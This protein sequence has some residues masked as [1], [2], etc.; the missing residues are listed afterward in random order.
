[1]NSFSGTTSDIQKAR[2]SLQWEVDVPTQ[3]ILQLDS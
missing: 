2:S 3:L 1:M